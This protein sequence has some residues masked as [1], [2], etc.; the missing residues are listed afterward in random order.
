MLM[1]L[2]NWFR[3]FL[4]VR[5]RGMAPE[6]F[7]NMCCNK[8]IYIW[9]LKRIEE[10]YQ[11]HITV[12]NYKKLKPIAKKT[13]MI[14]RIIRK[15][16]FPFFLY[17]YRKR[18]VF[19]IGVLICAAIVY[20]LSLF[21]WDISIQGGSKYTPEA[22]IKFLEDNHVYTGIRKEK[23]KCQEIEETIRLAYTDIG[24]V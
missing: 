6:R 13:K 20:I 18:K 11:F 2:I 1:K 8:K 15:T 21:I 14:P 3:G 7:I 24:W 23:V 9:D 17:R 12:K 10:D 16:G 4:C 19:F 5:I 22:M